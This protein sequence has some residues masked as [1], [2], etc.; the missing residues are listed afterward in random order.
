MRQ[1]TLALV[2]GVALIIVLAYSWC[3]RNLPEPTSRV[4]P[5]PTPA[6]A[7]PGPTVA[8]TVATPSISAP[9]AT[10]TAAAQTPPPEFKKV[11][12]KADPAIVELTL[13]DAKG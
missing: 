4:S 3:G 6:P 1:S 9:S 8:V 7:A 10:V 12:E 2:C 5:T 13:F 11:A